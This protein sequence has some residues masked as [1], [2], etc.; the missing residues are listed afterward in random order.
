MA[1]ER[2]MINDYLIIRGYQ[3]T[4]NSTNK[5]IKNIIISIIF[6]VLVIFVVLFLSK[7]IGTIGDTVIITI[8]LL[9]ILIYLI[10]SGRLSGLKA[11]DL[12]AK[13]VDITVQS[14]EIASETI[15][16]SVNDMVI[17]KKQGARELL[18]NIPELNKSKPIILTLILGTST[19]YF[20]E[21]WFK[22]ME[23]LSQFNTF[24]FVV[25]L[26]KDKKFIAFITSRAIL[27]I[28]RIESLGNEFINTLNDNKIQE[29][30]LFPGIVSTTISTMSTNIEALSEMTK[31]NLDAL[32]VIDKNLKLEGVV[33]R[34]QL[35]SKLIL[36]MAK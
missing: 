7:Y 8:L 18:K 11:G 6:L 27:Q 21:S 17:V 3:M 16:P 25:F 13:F 34:E 14:I 23:A 15:T 2:N 29:L 20:Y 36:G 30:K 28:L 32:I 9:P 26:D 4:S 12:E 35:L 31:Q 24:K 33:E 19:S 1:K 22:Y 5:E 10:F